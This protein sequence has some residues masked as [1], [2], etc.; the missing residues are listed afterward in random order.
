M[1]KLVKPKEETLLLNRHYHNW[2]LIIQGGTIQ[3]KDR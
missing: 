1:V 2:N 3:E